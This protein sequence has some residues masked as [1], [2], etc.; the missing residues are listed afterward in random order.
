MDIEY[1]P[2]TECD[3]E[4]LLAWRSHPKLYENFYLQEGPLD[5][6]THKEWWESREHRR[7][8]I[9]IVNSEKRWR[10]VGSVNVTN[11]DTDVPEIGIYVGEITLWGNGVASDA[12]EFAVN[13]TRSQGY[14]AVKARVLEHNEAS[15]QVFENLG[16]RK[17][18]AA[19]G[20]EFEYRKPI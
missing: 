9:I 10:G 6:E 12:V 19:R 8:W 4:L 13:W 16:F 15:R 14:S 20:N 2:A 3:L 1:R 18:G 7:D 11:L 17:V 5:W